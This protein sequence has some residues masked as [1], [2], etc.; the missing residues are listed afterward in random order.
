MQKQLF[1]NEASKFNI[2][3][4]DRK[5]GVGGKATLKKLEK[6]FFIKF[7]KDFLIFSKCFPFIG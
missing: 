6:N 5:N 1:Q 3:E 4:A 2:D 7:P